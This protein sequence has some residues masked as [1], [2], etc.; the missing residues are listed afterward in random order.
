[1]SKVFLG[2]ASGPGMSLSTAKRFAREGYDIVLS[3]RNI[4]R[5]RPC[6]AQIEALGAKVD[7][8]QVD[9]SDP[10]GVAALVASVGPNLE[11]LRRQRR[12]AALQR[13][14]AEHAFPR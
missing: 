9:A 8:R 13:R 3:A 7:V 4:E 6:A 1:M 5:L 2:I 11:V 14:G 12:V 10:K